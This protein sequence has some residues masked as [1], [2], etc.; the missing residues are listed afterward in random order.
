MKDFSIVVFIALVKGFVIAVQDFSFGI[1]CIMKPLSWQE[2]VNNCINA[3]GK[4][5]SFETGLGSDLDKLNL[6]SDTDVWIANYLQKSNEGRDFCG[7]NYLNRSYSYSAEVFYGYCDTNR[8]YFCKTKTATG[9]TLAVYNSTRANVSCNKTVSPNDLFM[10]SFQIKPGFY[11]ST[12]TIKAVEKEGTVQISNT[13]EHYCGAYKSAT[14]KYF[15]KCSGKR[16]S[17]CGNFEPSTSSW[18]GKINTQCFDVFKEQS[19]PNAKQPTFESKVAF[20]SNKKP[21]TSDSNMFASSSWKAHIT[22]SSATESE[23]DKMSIQ[24]GE[25]KEETSDIGVTIGIPIGIVLLLMCGVLIILYINR[26]RVKCWQSSNSKHENERMNQFHIQG[27]SPTHGQ[28]NV[29]SESI[30]QTSSSDYRTNENNFTD[31]SAQYAIVTKPKKDDTKS[32]NDNYSNKSY[33][34]AT[35][36]EYDVAGTFQNSRCNQ[37]DNLYNHSESADEYNSTPFVREEEGCN[38]LYNTTEDRNPV[39]STYDFTTEV[40]NRALPDDVYN[41]LS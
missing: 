9:H 30:Q 6:K 12:R 4:L 29:Y 25:E 37:S 17:L 7:F 31:D 23:I 33:Q 11:W 27:T 32:R 20:V 40:N 28:L 41:H 10:N 3:G 5:V 2:A 15:A 26:R 8:N 19:T 38:N 13:N 16:L 35:N 36:D 1:S 34:N 14:G 39:E 22:T 18:I 21:V 24:G